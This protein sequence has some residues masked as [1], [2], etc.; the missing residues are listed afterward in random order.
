MPWNRSPEAR[1][2][3]RTAAGALTGG[4]IGMFCGCPLSRGIGYTL[5]LALLF[6]PFSARTL[7]IIAWGGLILSGVA[8]GAALGYLARH[9]HW[10]D[11]S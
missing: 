9:L 6:V 5:E 2:V 11:L 7:G 8:I 1:T 4:L 3:F 10:D